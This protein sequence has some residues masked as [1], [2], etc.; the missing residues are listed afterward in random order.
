MPY[1]YLL[2]AHNTK[3]L[4][5][6]MFHTTHLDI[7]I[8]V[9]TGN[10]SALSHF[11]GQ[12]SGSY[13]PLGMNIDVPFNESP[14]LSFLGGWSFALGGGGGGDLTQFSAFVVYRSVSFASF[15]PIIGIGAT[16]TWYNTNVDSGD[17]RIDF[18]GSLVAPTVLLGFEPV[19]GMVDVL[20]AVPLISRLT[21]T[22]DDKSY[23]IEPFTMRLNLV[24][25]F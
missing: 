16:E 5:R 10:F 25:S 7:S 24:I 12:K 22:F 1:E 15:N 2:L 18:S 23:S 9:S 17:Y 20:L 6:P 4:R 13:A 14:D 11:I 8:G 21:T 3:G 19:P